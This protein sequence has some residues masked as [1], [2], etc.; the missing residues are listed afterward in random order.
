MEIVQV[1]S[2]EQIVQARELFAEYA[3]GLGIDLS[4]QNFEHELAHLPGSYSPPDGRLL[5]A[6]GDN[7]VIG[8]VA[9]RRIDEQI[10]EMKR[11]YVRPTFR[12]QQLGRRLALAVIEAAKQIG[13][14][15]M[16]L[17]TLP[18]MGPAIKMYRSLG[19]QEIE[20]YTVN[21]V[22]GALF[23]TLQL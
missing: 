5:L 15:S 8:C 22:P 13:Y 4:F 3:A 16:L 19:F 14:E 18:S 7:T 21:P 23:M 2:A 20:P 17:D 12:S 6:L 11:L 1:R 10:C 9:L